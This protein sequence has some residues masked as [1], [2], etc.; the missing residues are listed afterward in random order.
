TQQGKA[1]IYLVLFLMSVSLNVQFPIFTPYAVALGASSFFV[2]LMVSSSSLTNLGGNIMAGPIIDRI[3]KKPFIVVP[4]F[5]SSFLMAGHALADNAQ[6]LFILRILNGFV[7]AFLS[8][9]C[10]ALLSAY[11]KNTRE[12]G[13]NM[14]INGLMVTLATVVAPF[15]GGQLVKIFNYSETYWFIG[16][17]LFCT[18]IIALFY[19]REAEPIVVYRKDRPSFAEMLKS[20]SLLPLYFIG[21]ALMYGHG[22]LFYE[23]P[24]LSVEHGFS[25]AETGKLFSLMGIGT[26]VSLS[27]F[28]LNRFSALLR[29]AIGMFFTALLYYQMA[30]SVF[31]IDL[32][33]TLFCMGISFGLLFPAI[34]TLLTEIVGQDRY[35]SA[36]GVLSAVFSLGIIVSSVI[37][38]AIRDFM[39]PYYLAFLVTMGGTFY[40]VY[41]YLKTKRGNGATSFRNNR[42]QAG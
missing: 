14:A 30:T 1:A 15:T 8:P 22:T 12:Q 24:F 42:K 37:S 29:T 40:V 11:A 9:A 16:G 38:G 27:L 28:W 23:L 35:G 41:D 34:T 32:G 39:S 19:I 3:G 17:A 6:E 13:K 10:F 25:T 26:F 2:S 4:L 36:F 20:R 5:L 21:F 31:P 18:G 7:L 33:T